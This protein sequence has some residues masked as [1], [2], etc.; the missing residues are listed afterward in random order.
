MTTIINYLN[1]KFIKEIE[2]NEIN[3]FE[4]PTKFADM[5][6][7]LSESLRGLG[8]NIIKEYLEDLND[9]LKK[10]SKRKQNWVIEKHDTKKLITSLGEVD[11]SKTLFTSKDCGEMQYLIDSI[12]GMKPHQLLTEDAKVRLYTEA[13]DTSYRRGGEA[14]TVDSSSEISKN[15][16]KDIIMNTK[17]PKTYTESDEK[18][19][20]KTLY[21]DA[22]EDHI[23]LQFQNKKVDLRKNKLGNKNNCAIGKI[24]YVYEGITNVKPGSKRKR[25]LN[26]MYFGSVLKKNSELWE[27]VY[28]YIKSIYD[29]DYLETIY[30][31][32]DG[33]TWIKAGKD[34][35]PGCKYV[36]DEFHLSKYLLKMTSHMMDTQYDAKVE[37][38]EAIKRGT[39]ADFIGVKD[40][41]IALADKET[42]VERIEESSKYILS[43]WGAAKLRLS[44]RTAIYGCSAEGH[45]SHVL[46]DRM[47]SR[48]M[49]WSRLGAEK[50]L[51]LR[52]YKYNHGDMLKL[53]RYQDEYEELPMVAGL[54]DIKIDIDK[55]L[56]IMKTK[57]R[58]SAM[59]YEEVIHHEISP[60]VS[61]Q[62]MFHLNAVL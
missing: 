4:N 42:T 15:A 24:I 2:N 34:Y 3:F 46:S 26:T 6:Y 52:I 18:K 22:D 1:E 25:L 8:L 13:C 5:I 14:I 44:N 11:F 59:K 51:S 61:K 58:A 39:K 27:E 53:V 56:N 31:N 17:F 35:L 45:V 41:L 47:S 48:P 40:R 33:A 7:K 49:G 28:D 20:V 37:L 55:K 54:E 38:C 29:V 60:Q 36:L 21:I 10:S 23:A 12:L 19:K 62:L 9:C 57:A 30:L 16:V 43:N 50:M 32:G